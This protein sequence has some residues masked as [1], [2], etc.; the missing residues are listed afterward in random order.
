M[1]APMVDQRSAL[2]REAKHDDLLQLNSADSMARTAREADQPM[3]MLA[4]GPATPL[5]ARQRA[6]RN[7]PKKAAK[8]I[9]IMGGPLT[10][11]SNGPALIGT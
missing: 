2:Q 3:P 1:A 5:A 9:L 7:P 4:A 10:S 8:A 11:R 6:N